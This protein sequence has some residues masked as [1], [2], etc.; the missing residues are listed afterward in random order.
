MWC[1]VC[2]GAVRCGVMR[3]D[4]VWCG[5]VWCGGVYILYC[6]VLHEYR[7]CVYQPGVGND[8]KDQFYKNIPT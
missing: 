3:Y 5:A 4:V 2:G 8:F 7:C 1:G 6:I